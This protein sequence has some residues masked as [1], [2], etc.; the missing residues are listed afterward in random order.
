MDRKELARRVEIGT[1]VLLVVVLAVI[2]V[3]NYDPNSSKIMEE[4]L[5]RK[6]HSTSTANEIGSS[7]DTSFDITN[8]SSTS[9]KINNTPNTTEN[10]NSVASSVPN[11]T[12]S[13]Q[14]PKTESSVN[15]TPKTDL[16]NINYADLDQLQQL[17]GIGKVKAQAIID[18]R[19]SH[20]AFRTIDELVNVDGIGEKTL[21]K[22]RS[23]IT[24]DS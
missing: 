17:D 13:S 4:Y 24:V 15:N 9:E 6:S 16:I 5:N 11:S 12:V 22:N 10:N 7:K 19:E 3:L 18:Y 2:F 8:P 20:G 14:S 21:E 23:R 1:M